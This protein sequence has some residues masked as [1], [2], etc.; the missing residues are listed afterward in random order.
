MVMLMRRPLRMCDATLPRAMMCAAFQSAVDTLAS[1][2]DVAHDD[3]NDR[4]PAAHHT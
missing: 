2:S 4:D 1:S 3:S